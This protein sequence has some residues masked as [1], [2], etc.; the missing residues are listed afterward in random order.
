L[1]FQKLEAYTQGEN[2]SIRNYYNE[3]IKL[4]KEADPAMSE[5]AK[6]RYLLN[7]TK[8]TIQFEV[9]RKKPTTTKEFLEYAKEIEDLYQLSNISI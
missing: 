6:L 4:C 8:P 9:R 7:K 5:S 1:A 3:V 2:Q